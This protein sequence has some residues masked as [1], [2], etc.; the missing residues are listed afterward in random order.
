[1][2]TVYITISDEESLLCRKFINK[3]KIFNPK[4]RTVTLTQ[5][6][7]TRIKKAIDTEVRPHVE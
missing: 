5:L 1:M 2:S 7:T 3:Y 6:L 4:G